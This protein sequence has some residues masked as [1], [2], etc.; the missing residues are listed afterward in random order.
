MTAD[1]MQILVF[2]AGSAGGFYAVLH[3]ISRYMEAHAQATLIKAQAVLVAAQATLAAAQAEAVLIKAK[4]DAAEIEARNKAEVIT[5]TL[6]KQAADD[7]QQ[8]TIL[9]LLVLANQQ[10]TASRFEAANRWTGGQ[11]TPESRETDAA[12]RAV[13]A[14]VV[15]GGPVPPAGHPPGYVELAPSTL[16]SV[17]SQPIVTPPV[18]AT[19]EPGTIPKLT[20]TAT[21]VQVSAPPTVAPQSAATGV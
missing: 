21:D 11:S 20:I 16:P 6:R 7:E 2:F 9:N 3:A 8:K 10:L 5:A 13:D 15:A 19:P 12:H 1:L 17:I 4:A 18:L 14:S